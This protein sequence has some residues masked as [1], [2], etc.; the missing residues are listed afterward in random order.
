MKKLARETIK[1][2]VLY[3][4]RGQDNQ[5]DILKN[6][7]GSNK[8]EEFINNLGQKVSLRNHL[9]FQAGL[10]Y[11]TDG[12]VAV[13]HSD[14]LIELMFHVATMM[15]TSADDDQ[16]LN[17]K[18][19]YRDLGLVIIS[20]RHV[21]NDHVNIVWCENYR[22]YRRNTITSQY[23]FVQII[24]YPMKFDL[25]KVVVYRKDAINYLFPWIDNMIISREHLPLL[26]KLC[27]V[28]GFRSKNLTLKIFF[29]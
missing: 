7:V 18:K 11:K 10:K 13:Y 22:G 2:G 8:Y 23:N 20:I 17:K 25:C 21:G 16:V 9:G 1:I 24:V 29:L 15:P 28:H 5:R 3:V 4:A 14:P 27:S 19:Y 12:K 6:I 26:V